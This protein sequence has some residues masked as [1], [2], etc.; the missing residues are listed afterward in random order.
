MRDTSID[1]P[2]SAGTYLYGVTYSQ[3]FAG[4]GT[5]IQA[6]GIAGSPIRVVVQAD[7]AAIV[8]DSPVDQYDITRENVTAHERVVEEAMQRAD[9][10]PV[11][12]GTVARSDQEVR[13]R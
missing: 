1:Q 10:L 2:Q 13:E 6:R 9:V 11:S 3:P 8:S 12:F 7:L 5:W 4:D